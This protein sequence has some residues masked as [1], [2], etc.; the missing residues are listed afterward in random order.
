MHNHRTFIKLGNN[1]KIQMSPEQPLYKL[2]RE[3]CPI[4]EK[5]E[6]RKRIGECYSTILS[7]TSQSKGEE[8]N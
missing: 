3:H 4:T 1:T 5:A 6:L 7:S 2:M 8:Q